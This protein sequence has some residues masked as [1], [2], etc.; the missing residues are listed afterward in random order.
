MAYGNM[1]TTKMRTA[2]SETVRV[3]K[4][5]GRGLTLGEERYPDSLSTRDKV[6]E[7]KN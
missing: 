1:R 5:C 3:I 2:G 7:S 6:G 4:T